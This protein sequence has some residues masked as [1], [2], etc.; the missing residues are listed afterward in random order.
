M[1]PFHIAGMSDHLNY[2][3]SSK[4]VVAHCL[5]FQ[6]HAAFVPTCNSLPFEMVH[7]AERRI[8]PRAARASRN[9]QGNVARIRVIYSPTKTG[10]GVDV[11]D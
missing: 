11:H 9:R 5:A 8:S 4:Q 1:R 10:A 6:S 7:L 2:D 3:R